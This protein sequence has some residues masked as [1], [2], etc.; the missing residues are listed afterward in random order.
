[1]TAP[2]TTQARL[3]A[4]TAAIE[5]I[6]GGSQ[7]YWIGNRKCRRGDLKTLYMQEESLLSRL[8]E[9]AAGDSMTSL[10]VYGGV[11]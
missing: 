5:A 2:R 6:E 9:E 8:R 11:E 4:V 1:M 10:G 7:E 3:E